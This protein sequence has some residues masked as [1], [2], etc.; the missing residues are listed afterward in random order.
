MGIQR[1][2]AGLGRDLQGGGSGTEDQGVLQKG[3]GTRNW[4]EEAGVGRSGNS[5]VASGLRR[6]QRVLLRTATTV[7]AP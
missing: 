4:D 3:A 6:R 5:R 2:K 7:Q 1:G